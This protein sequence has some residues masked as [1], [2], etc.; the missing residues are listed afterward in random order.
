MIETVNLRAGYGGRE[1]LHGVTLTAQR[2]REKHLFKSSGGH[3]PP[4]GRGA[5]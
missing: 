4:G 2:L 1:I 3:R 5:H